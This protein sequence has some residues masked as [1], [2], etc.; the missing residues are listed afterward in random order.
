M[1]KSDMD[2]DIDFSKGVQ[3]YKAR[4]KAAIDKL[5]KGNVNHL[6][7]GDAL[8]DLKKELKI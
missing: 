5:E 2:A 1:A 7:Y 3:Y 6:D 8:S 4:V